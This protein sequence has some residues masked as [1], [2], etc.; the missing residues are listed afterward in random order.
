M[1]A[2]IQVTDRTALITGVRQLSG[3]PVESFDIRAAAA[4]VVAGLAARGVTSVL[5]PQ[6]LR[7][8]YDSLVQKLTALGASVRYRISDPE[9]FIFTGC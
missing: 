6:H 5:E 3:A 1:G 8:G 2:R 9:D 7:R 4:L